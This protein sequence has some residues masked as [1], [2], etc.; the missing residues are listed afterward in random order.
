MRVVVETPKWSFVKYKWVGGDFVRELVSPIPNLFNY[1]FVEGMM[2]GDGMP[3]D[4]LILGRRIRQGEKIDYIIVGKVQFIDNGYKDDKLIFS[5]NGKFS[6]YD[7][8][9]IRI[10][11]FIYPIFKLLYYIIVKREGYSFRYNGIISNKLQ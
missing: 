8:L 10:F 1:G 6:H 5:E 2:G 11:Y 9:K 3:Q 4:A 7:R